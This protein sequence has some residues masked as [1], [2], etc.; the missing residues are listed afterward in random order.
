[1]ELTIRELADLVDGLSTNDAP[2][3]MPLPHWAI[4]VF[5]RGWVFVGVVAEGETIVRIEKCAVIRRWGTLKGLGELRRGPLADTKLD[6]VDT[7]VAPAK[8]LIFTIGV[9]ATAW[10]GKT[11]G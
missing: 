3:A 8:S 4:A 1:M 10:D 11:D 7:L 2:P 6:P 9:D 5:D